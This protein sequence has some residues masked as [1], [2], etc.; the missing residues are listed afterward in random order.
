MGMI[1]E[2]ADK[3]FATGMIPSTQREVIKRAVMMAIDSSIIVEET[4]DSS[5]ERTEPAVNADH[6]VTDGSDPQDP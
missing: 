6:V 1:K 4:P 5:H 2:E 3:L